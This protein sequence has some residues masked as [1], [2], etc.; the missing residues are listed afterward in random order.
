VN[1]VVNLFTGIV[2]EVKSDSM[3]VSLTVN[4]M[5]LY[6]NAMFPRNYLL[7]QCNHALFDGGCALLKSTYAISGTASGSSN[8]VSTFQSNCT[9]ADG[10]FA[11]G[12]VV[13]TSGANAGITS[14]VKSYAN[15]SGTFTLIYPLAV[16]PSAGDTFTAYPGC[17]KLQATCSSKFNNLSHFR[18]FPYAPTPETLE[19]GGTGSQAP[20]ATGGS[21]GAGIVRLPRGQGGLQGNF[22]QQ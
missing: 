14:S 20:V 4:S 5:L 3:K 22:K 21:G 15:A 1:G 7:P 6:L 18:G 12:S 9:Q 17:D 19:V 10:W 8:T 16:A 13:W 11:L 2:G